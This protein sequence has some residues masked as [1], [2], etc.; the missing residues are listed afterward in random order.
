M[1]IEEIERLERQE[2]F[3]KKAILKHKNKFD[4]SKVNYIDSI[5]N[6]TIVCNKH[7]I[8]FQQK[9]VK[10]LQNKHCCPICAKE[11][12]S[13]AVRI[14]KEDFINKAKEIHGDSF[15]YEKTI[16]KTRHD[17]VIIYCKRHNKYFEQRLNVHL[18][19]Y[20]GCKECL[21][22]QKIKKNRQQFKQNFIDSFIEKFGSNY[23]FS[24]VEYINNVSPVKIYCKKHKVWFS[25]VHRNIKRSKT[26]SCPKCKKEK[27]I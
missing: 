12:Y 25:Q 27:L 13:K 18:K 21:R 23:D 5:S 11:A 4:Y 24:K 6:I 17:K 15:S 3:L 8:E 14:N 9:P 22:E 20:I 1:F 16:P 19:G 10:H 2:E 7:K 26:C